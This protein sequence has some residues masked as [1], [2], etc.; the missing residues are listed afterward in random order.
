MRNENGFLR[1]RNHKYI[2][3]APDDHRLFCWLRLVTRGV[4]C[5]RVLIEPTYCQ[6][7]ESHSNDDSFPGQA[8][9]SVLCERW[10]IRYYIFSSGTGN[11]CSDTIEIIPVARMF[12][13]CSSVPK[14]SCLNSYRRRL[15]GYACL[16]PSKNAVITFLSN[17][18]IYSRDCEQR[19]N[20]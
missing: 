9:A 1:A 16:S 17:K 7:D 2:Y 8:H 10:K 11:R 13:I 12:V 14:I 3:Y 15:I 4:F 19:N 18:A 6:V 5:A 20:K